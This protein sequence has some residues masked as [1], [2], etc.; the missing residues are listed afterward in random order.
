MPSAPAPRWAKQLLVSESWRHRM[1]AVIAERRRRT[2]CWTICR[3]IP[4]GCRRQIG[5]GFWLTAFTA[6]TQL[7]EFVLRETAYRRRMMHEIDP[8]YWIAPQAEIRPVV[9]GADAGRHI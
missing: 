8:E 4:R 7:V 6:R 5:G 3:S 2:S 9:P 1:I